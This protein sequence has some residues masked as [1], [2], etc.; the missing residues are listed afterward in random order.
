LPLSLAAGEADTA[1]VDVDIA[2]DQVAGDLADTASLRWTD[3]NGN[4]YG[5]VSSSFTTTVTT[6]PDAQDTDGSTGDGDDLV[7]G[8]SLTNP[9]VRDV[10]GT[11]VLGGGCQYATKL[12]PPPG[13]RS[14]EAR[15]LSDDPGACTAKIEVGIPPASA[16]RSDIQDAIALGIEPDAIPA[17]TA[18]RFRSRRARTAGVCASASCRSIDEM[19]SWMEDP[20]FIDVNKVWTVADWRW[21]GDVVLS[22]RGLHKAKPTSPI[23]DWYLSSQRLRT[24]QT[25]EKVSARSYVQFKNKDFVGC[26]GHWTY[27]NYSPNKALG[28]PNGGG[29]GRMRW[30]RTGA[31]CRIALHANSRFTMLR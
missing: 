10:T 8:D 13:Y 4:A 3:E 30:S 18:A 25:D 27:I 5:P 1:H 9:I 2:S 23:T 14:V 19:K 31:L 28:F 11:K 22:G 17:V 24:V 29:D 16:I 15:E 21:N 26:L 6:P 20:L 12:V 7:A